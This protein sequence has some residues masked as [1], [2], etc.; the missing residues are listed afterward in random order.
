MDVFLIICTILIGLGLFGVSFYLLAI[1]CHPDDNGIGT[2]ILLKILVIFGLALSWAQVLMVPLDVANARSGGGLD[3][4]TFW[5]VIYASIALMITIL[6]PFA[7][8]LYE[9]DEDKN[10]VKFK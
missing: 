10:I 2:H 4:Q 7:I 3:M 9:T 5:F 6:L 1:Y 8:F